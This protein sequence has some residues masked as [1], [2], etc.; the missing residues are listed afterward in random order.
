MEKKDL[1]NE[2]SELTE[3]LKAAASAYY[4]DNA[5]LMGNFE[6]DKLYD[7]LLLLETRTGVVF[8]GSPTQRVGWGVSAGLVKQE[9]PAPMLSLNKTKSAD[10]LA[11][12]LGGQMGLLSYKLDGLTVALTYRG[13]ALDSA[14]T[15]GNGAVGEIVTNNARAFT[16]LPLKIP[17][18]GELVL[19]GEAVIRYTD[20]EKI[21]RDIESV[22]AKYKNPR[23]LVSGSVRQLDSAVTARRH[24]RFCAF[25]LVGTS[26]APEPGAWTSRNSQMQFLRAQGFET[27][28]F[29]LVV[30]GGLPEAIARFSKTAAAPGFD[31]PVDGLV[32][33]YDDVA[34]SESL[35]AT[36][37]YPRDAM[38]FKWQDEEAETELLE[39]EW[40][41]S[42]TGLINPVAVF[43]SVELEGT[44]V[45]RAS[46]HNV[47][48]LEELALGKGDTIKVYKANMIIPQ[49]S[50]NLTRS[51]SE[52]PPEACPVCGAQTELRDADGAR[53]LF[54][55]NEDCPARRIK[56]FAHFVSRPC[57]NIEGLS[58]QTLEKFIAAGL[59]REFADVFRLAAHR[60][61]IVEMEGLG[62][63]SFENLSAA[64]E[65]GRATTADR[66]LASLGIPEVGTATAKAIARSLGN[67]WP[68]VAG[69]AAE[70]LAEIEGVGPVIA[71]LYTAW[72]ADAKNKAMADAVVSE[73]RFADPPALA[74]ATG[75]PLAGKTF[76]ITGSLT[77][78]A[79]RDALKE[80]IEALGGKTAGSVS[81]KTDY[82]INN[83]AMSQSSKNKTARALGVAVITEAG[84]E[85]LAAGSPAQPPQ[86][87]QS[88]EP[89]L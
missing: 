6:Y 22:D 33:E 87:G 7:E 13:G 63:R 23:N 52:H 61:A 30:A 66:L 85:A 78:Y 11:E 21:N 26:P 44:T 74:H 81:A 45:S 58:E 10:E 29:E 50:E 1:L 2:Q 5:E 20:F 31:M 43:R 73:V 75:A 9:H 18:T 3:R 14:V 56:A 83:D 76:V 89:L 86:P 4:D 37:K 25:A 69:A 49:I 38:A 35:G 48:I 32:L 71:G 70:T 51:G 27:V 64:I 88:G 40:S 39:I 8:A 36:S 42:R 68:R 46:V 24:V 47:S 28:D 65:L 34:Y 54:C 60:A 12:W 67:D 59:L 57:M 79:N 84:F 41:A 53:T 80:K 55:T 15:R 19:R 62:E 72:F 77:G 17:Y 82:L 16:N